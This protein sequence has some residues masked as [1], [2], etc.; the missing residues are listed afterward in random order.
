MQVKWPS[1]VSGS[2]AV[3]ETNANGFGC[4]GL[5]VSLPV[6]VNPTP[7]LKSISGKWTL[8]S[9]ETGV[10]Y[11]VPSTTG[12]TYSWLVGGGSIVSGNS[13]NSIIVNWGSVSSGYNVSPIQ[14]RETSSTG[15]VGPLSS[16]DVGVYAKPTTG[17]ITGSATVCPNSTIAYSVPN[18]S[19]STYLWSVTGGTQ[20][21]GTNTNSISV[22]WGNNGAGSLSVIESDVRG[23]QGQAVV[24]S[25]TINS[26][27]APTIT[28]SGSTSFCQGGSVTLTSS[29]SSSYLWST[30]ATT[31]SIMV[32]ISGSY[33]VTTSN[34]NGCTAT[35]AA[36]TVTVNPLPSATITPSGATTFCQ[37]SSVTL[38]GPAGFNYQWL[39]GNTLLSVATN[40]SLVVTSTRGLPSTSNRCF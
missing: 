23:C 22:T 20:I 33:T 34:A 40:R 24:K 11:S 35:S 10:L 13:S 6:T 19:G 1:G 38:T 4:A 31:Q 3:V 32:S 25:V 15:C 29:A 7:N 18:T 39:H 30:G 14:V 26:G 37:G 8:C 9:G 27:P 5:V 17:L 36:T 12:S 28:S 21:S 16:T 2:V